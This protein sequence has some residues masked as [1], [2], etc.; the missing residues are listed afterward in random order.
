MHHLGG[1]TSAAPRRGGHPAEGDDVPLL[2]RL[3]AEREPGRA[4][5]CRFDYAWFTPRFY[6]AG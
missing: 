2:S 4:G 5:L 1:V 3:P 6:W